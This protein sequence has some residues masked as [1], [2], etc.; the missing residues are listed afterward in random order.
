MGEAILKVFIAIFDNDES[1]RWR[2]RV[3]RYD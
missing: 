3:T 2:G 1:P